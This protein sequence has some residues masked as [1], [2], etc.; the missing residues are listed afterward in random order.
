M[1]RAPGRIFRVSEG[2][3]RLRPGRLRAGLAALAAIA[4]GLGIA[5]AAGGGE[6]APPDSGQ[7]R[8]ATEPPRTAGGQPGEPASTAPPAEPESGVASEVPCSAIEREKKVLEEEK[9]AAEENARDDKEA[10]EAI[11]AQFE[12]EKKALGERAKRCKEG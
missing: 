9:K 10:K 1:G 11:K 3:R 4:L 6:E 12:A 8:Q 7:P 5:L 2:R